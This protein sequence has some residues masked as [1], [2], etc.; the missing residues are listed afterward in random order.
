MGGRAEGRRGGRAEGLAGYLA[1]TGTHLHKH[2][3]NDTTHVLIC[4]P[5]VCI[6]YLGDVA[7][8]GKRIGERPGHFNDKKKPEGFNT[9]KVFLSPSIRYAGVDTYASPSK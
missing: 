5:F 4:I 6:C 1:G 2:S 9:K 7:P 8:D 3:D